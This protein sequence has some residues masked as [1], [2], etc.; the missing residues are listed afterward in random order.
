MI[1][2]GKLMNAGRVVFGSTVTL[3]HVNDEVEVTYQI[4]GEDEADIK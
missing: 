1:D 4:V 3:V 2:I